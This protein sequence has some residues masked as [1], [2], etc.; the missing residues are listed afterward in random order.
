[1]TS[2]VYLL[3]YGAM[4]TWLAPAPLSWLTRRGTN[5]RLG[6]AA[7]VTAMA[8]VLVAWTVAVGV[9]AVSLVRGGPNS[10][11]IVLCLELLGV[12][13]HEAT[14]GAFAATVL[15]AVGVLI[16]AVVTVGVGRT[17]LGL[18]LHSAEHADAARII[19]TPTD[20]DGVFVVAGE[21]PAAY[22]VVGRPD[23][24]VVTTAAVRALD[25][26]ELDAVLAHEGAH[27]AGRHHHLLMVLRALAASLAHLPLFT[28][29]AVAVAELLEMCADD[30]AARRH[31]P[32][33]LVA[34][35]L[36]LASPLPPV[37]GLAMAATA[38]AAR[39]RRLL[40]PAGRSTRWCHRVATS[41]TIA[42]TI[43]APVVVNVLCHH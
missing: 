7:W 29:G 36:A 17:V 40:D 10:S 27:I 2:T 32:R 41:A 43:G 21:R 15:L 4:V 14:L 3:L 1:M 5:P 19:G 6:I 22:C 35:M 34:G 13:E 38:T 20:A 23:T 25:G 39:A 37:G 42:A 8:G 16:S 9:V 26:P 31:G 28:R 24:I 30:T 12:P 18:R 11:V 33:P